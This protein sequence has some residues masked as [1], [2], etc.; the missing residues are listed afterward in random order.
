[1]A[2]PVCGNCGAE[3]T[4][5]SRFCGRCGVPVTVTPPPLPGAILPPDRPSTAPPGAGRGFPV[6]PVLILLAGVIALVVAVYLVQRRHPPAGEALLGQG[7]IVPTPSAVDSGYAL[8]PP[9]VGA[10]ITPVA[11]APTP[12]VMGGL[13]FP[14]PGFDAEPTPLPAPPPPPTATP[15]PPIVAVFEAREAARFDVSPDD[16]EISVNG[17]VIGKADDW[18]D[19][20]GGELYEFERPGVYYVKLTLKGHRTTWVKIVVSEDAGE[21]VAKVD[22]ELKSDRGKDDRKADKKGKK[23]KKDKDRDKEKEEEEED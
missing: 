18:D 9:P 10:V 13:S 5:G 17:K 23:D 16:A 20:C 15:T 4:P 1:M 19:R 22:T 8:M 21:K 12:E 2:G 14:T 11:A 7:S 3:A 6:L